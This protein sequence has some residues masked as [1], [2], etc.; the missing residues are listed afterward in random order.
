MPSNHLLSR[1]NL[2]SPVTTFSPLLLLPCSPISSSIALPFLV[3]PLIPA[4]LPAP[5]PTLPK[6]LP[7]PKPALS[8]LYTLHPGLNPPQPLCYQLRLPVDARVPR[9]ILLCLCSLPPPPRLP[10]PLTHCPS[11]AKTRRASLPAAAAAAAAATA[12]ATTATGG[13]QAP[14]RFFILS[15]K[16]LLLPPLPSCSPTSTRQEQT[17]PVPAPLVSG[18]FPAVQ[19]TGAAED[20]TG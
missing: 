10:S 17:G 15:P 9:D 3:P 7:L 16:P 20:N 1:L 4:L 13:G 14:P 6:L 8:L 11:P 12:A 5:P 18:A 2:C 19:T